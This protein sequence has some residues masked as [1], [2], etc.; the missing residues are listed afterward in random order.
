MQ[1]AYPFLSSARTDAWLRHSTAPLLLSGRLV[2]RVFRPSQWTGLLLSPTVSPSPS[3]PKSHS[4]YYGDFIDTRRTIEPGYSPPEAR[5]RLV[6]SQSEI[7]ACTAEIGFRTKSVLKEGKAVQVN[8]CSP[9]NLLNSKRCHQYKGAALYQRLER[10]EKKAKAVSLYHDRLSLSQII[11]LPGR[12]Q[13]PNS[14]KRTLKPSQKNV[15][16]IDSLGG[17]FASPSETKWPERAGY[18]R[19]NLETSLDLE[20]ER[21]K[22]PIK[23]PVPRRSDLISYKRLGE[24]TELTR[25]LKAFMPAKASEVIESKRSLR[26]RP[27]SIADQFSPSFKL[28]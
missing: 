22:S 14:P 11:G 13:A 9:G 6:R 28:F 1:V 17:H 10:P 16:Q 15:S 19:R 5:G 25:R 24:E 8:T 12:A 4:P 3:P 2:K 23:S 20:P 26:V 21:R 27:A 7:P 18:M